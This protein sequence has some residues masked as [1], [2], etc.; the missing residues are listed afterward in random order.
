MTMPFASN[1]GLVGVSRGASFNL[2]T[3]VIRLLGYDGTGIVSIDRLSQKRPGQRGSTDLG[4][5]Q[6]DRFLALT[7][8]IIGIGLEHYYNSARST[9][10]DCF[11]ETEFDPIQLVFDIPG[12]GKR[13]I[14]ANLQGQLDFLANDRVFTLQ[15]V[16]AQL[17]ANDPRFYE[18]TQIT[19]D[20]YPVDGAILGWLMPW[21]LPWIF[22]ND[23][24]NATT[25][26]NY[27]N[28]DRLA[29]PEYPVLRVYGPIVDP[30]I[31]Q[32]TTG[33][34]IG[35]SGLSLGLG[36][37]VTIDLSGGAYHDSSPTIR[38]HLDESIENLLTDDDDLNTFHLAPAG[39]LLLDG[40]RSDG[41]NIIRLQGTG[42]T[43][44]T[45]LEIIY[46]NRYRGF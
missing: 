2:N 44:D 40:S 37:Y 25:T 10:L 41:N 21:P 36:E 18:P 19:V 12:V 43:D 38:N 6:S 26:I 30:I 42:A 4:F 33:D 32:E 24:A 23:V 46:Y 1:I 28:G 8:Q 45:R 15:T 14:D 17:K 7:W 9:L 27:A 31:T 39:K 29:A 22:G 13:A 11:A 16:D 20:L 5:A 35:F 34:T 3:P